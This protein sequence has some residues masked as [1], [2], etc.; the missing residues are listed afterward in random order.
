M[1]A[2]NMFKLNEYWHVPDMDFLSNKVKDAGPN[3]NYE[4]AFRDFVMANHPRTNVMVDV[5]AN[6]GIYSRPCSAFFKKVYA[7]EPI[8]KILECLKLNI[9]DCHNIEILE[10]GVGPFNP[11]AMFLYNPKNSGNTQQV[12][13]GDSTSSNLVI[14]KVIPLDDL[15]FEEI[16]YIKIDVEGFEADVL[17]SGVN[18][19]TANLPW[20]Q[21]EI[22]NNQ[23]RIEQ[24]LA[25]FGHYQ[26]V[27]IK[28]K[29]NRLYIPTEGKNKA[30]SG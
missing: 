14:S 25:Q 5:G 19:L 16:N 10:H 18:C 6:I 9:K 15:N 1:K 29:H 12:A 7:V 13:N 3:C 17:A 30:S 2:G 27:P 21:V 28:S 26:Y 20:I 22:N 11:H 24:W 4:K 23:T 8:P